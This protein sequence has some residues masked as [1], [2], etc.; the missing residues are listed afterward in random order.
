MKKQKNM[1]LKKLVIYKKII[2][3]KNYIKVYYNY[4]LFL[5]IYIGGQYV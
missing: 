3:E 1:L 2:I 5:E 4:K